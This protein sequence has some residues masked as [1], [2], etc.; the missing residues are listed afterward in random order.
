MEFEITTQKYT[1]QI[2]VCRP[3]FIKTNNSFERKCVYTALENINKLYNINV[4]CNRKKIWTHPISKYQM[5]QKHNEAL[6]GS[7]DCC[8]DAFCSG[9]YCDSCGYNNYCRHAVDVG[10]EMY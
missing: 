4:K 8:S 5:C 3:K 1:D 6:R 7:C 9:P 2:L 10:D